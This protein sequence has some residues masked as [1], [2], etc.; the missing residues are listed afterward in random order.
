MEEEK[1]AAAAALRLAAPLLNLAPLFIPSRSGQKR[2][3]NIAVVRMRRHG[4]RFEVACYKNK[5]ANWRAGVE[6]DLDEVLQTTAVFANV[7]RGVLAAEAD[8]AAAF[9]T[10]D[11]EA[12]CRLI[13]AGGDVQ[14]SDRERETEAAALFKDVAAAV[15]ARCVHPGT[16]RPYTATAVERALRGAGAALDPKRPAKAQALEAIGLLVRAGLPIER[17]R[18]RLRVSA[19]A[20]AAR[21]VTAALAAVGAVV[22]ATDLSLDGAD[23]AITCLADPGAFRAVH[24]AVGAGGVAEGARVEV[25]S[26]A[27]VDAGAAGGVGGSGAGA[28]T[29]PAPSAADQAA[30]EEAALRAAG[31]AGKAASASAGV[32]AGLRSLRVSGPSDE[33]DEAAAGGG[34]AP[35]GR[36]AAPTAAATTTAT[37]TTT[38][39]PRG[40][41]AGLPPSFGGARRALFEELDA[42]QAGWT[43]ELVCRGGGG[44]GGGGGGEAGAVDAVFYG[45]GG[46]RVGSFAVARRA[47]LKASKEGGGG[48]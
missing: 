42:L 26:V 2:L 40:P 38:T 28:A 35:A 12:V 8:V 11:A 20:A 14:V 30:A 48:G 6:T 43:V 25:L 39:Y 18:M 13:L 4:K 37:T 36:R 3:T 19:P 32:T 21:E 27:A 46:E 22:E 33:E 23:V 17:A 7:G 15:A 41:I 5:V 34:T 29:A 47:A 1:K 45:P 44:G 9:G 31:L 16:G 24:A 10:T